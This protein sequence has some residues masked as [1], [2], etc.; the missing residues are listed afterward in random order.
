MS[1]SSPDPAPLLVD[2][3]RTPSVSGE[4]GAVAERLAGWGRGL[5]LRTTLDDAGVRLEA[6]GSAPGP[7]L[8]L[9]SHLDTV[10]P[11][12][13]WGIDPFEGRIEGGVLRGRGASDAKGC[14]AAMASAVATVGRPARGRLVAVFTFGEE[15]ARTTMPAAVERLGRPDAAIVGEPTSLR[16]CIAQRGLLILRLRWRGRAAHA[17]WSSMLAGAAENAI[18]KAAAEIARVAALRFGREHDVLGFTSLNVTRLSAGT[19]SN[20]VPDLCEA[21]LDVRTTPAYSPDEIVERVRAEVSG[22]V[23]VVS[24]RFLPCETP[25]GSRLLPLVLDAA[26]DAAPFVSPTASDWVFLRDVDAVKLGPGD[27]TLSHT[28]DEQISLD[29]VVRARDLYAAIAA[30]YLA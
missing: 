16:P 1:T 9:A 18:H 20:V 2:L 24:R 19:A 17:G 28:V 23:E 21:T 26:P 8:W 22:E 15:T 10:P 27:S 3:V 14:V 12:E 11:G 5:G 25:E 29:E 4:E 7:T 13:G 30:R 6:E